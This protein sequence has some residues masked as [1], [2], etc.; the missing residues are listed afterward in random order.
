MNISHAQRRQPAGVDWEAIWQESCRRR[1]SDRNDRDFWNRRAPSFADHAKKTSYVTDFLRFMGPKPHWS[2]LDIGCG[3]GTLALP[4]ARMVREV[5]AI[6]F[7]EVMIDILTEQCRKESITNISPRVLGW[8]D[9]W[10]AAG[11]G[12]HDVAIASRSLVVPDLRG[13]LTKLND[14]ARHR[15]IIS[16]LVGD[17]PFDRKIFEAIGRELD[18]GPDY[19]CVYNLLYQMGILADVT[20]VANDCGAAVC[21]DLHKVYA[22]L[23]AAVEGYRW[24][25]D[26]MTNEEEARL[27]IYLEKHLVKKAGGYALSYHHPVRWAVISW[28]NS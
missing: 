4:L 23:E 11:V 12:R 5:T 22:D 20:F 10:Q 6:D 28:S 9:D 13:A 17:G 27:R 25:I 1:K 7:S 19:I 16:A 14:Y 8:Q 24:M 21:S 2:V 26:G 3:A 18:R 15:V